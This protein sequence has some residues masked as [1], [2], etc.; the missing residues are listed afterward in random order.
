VREFLRRLTT[1]EQSS[2]DALQLGC[3]ARIKYDEIE[4]SIVVL[5]GRREP[6]TPRVMGCIARE[7]SPYLLHVA[8]TVDPYLRRPGA[9]AGDALH[10]LADEG[11]L[12]Y[13]LLPP[14][15]RGATD[16]R[17]NPNARHDG[18]ASVVD[19]PQVDTPDRAGGDKPARV[20]PF[21]TA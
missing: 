21:A 20:L 19:P 17:V 16:H 7:H 3:R 6:Y 8:L 18:K 5:R 14:T 9:R 13:P 2:E 10:A 12:P 1:D 11:E 15:V 4:F